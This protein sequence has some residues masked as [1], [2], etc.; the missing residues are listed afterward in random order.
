MGSAVLTAKKPRITSAKVSQIMRPNATNTAPD[1]SF[2]ENPLFWKTPYSRNQ[3]LEKIHKDESLRRTS[4]PKLSKMTGLTALSQKPQCSWRV[5]ANPPVHPLETI[6]V[7]AFAPKSKEDEKVNVEKP[8]YRTE[9]V[10]IQTKIANRKMT[11]PMTT[12]TIS[13]TEDQTPRLRSF[14]QL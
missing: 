7:E 9:K 14:A 5:E 10:K 12:T 3:K 1:L 4:P 13:P 6:M 2:L 8:R 11:T